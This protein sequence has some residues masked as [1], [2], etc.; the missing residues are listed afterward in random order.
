MANEVELKVF[1]GARVDPELSS[2]LHSRPD[3][4]TSLEE[5]Y[6]E[7]YRYIGIYKENKEYTLKEIHA[8][9]EEI[10]HLLDYEAQIVMIPEVF[11]S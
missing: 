3:S 10:R 2:H 6:H 11:V 1:F 5:L 8:I 9:S 7:K 4:S